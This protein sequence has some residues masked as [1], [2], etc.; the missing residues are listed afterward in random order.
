MQVGFSQGFKGGLFGGMTFSQVDGDQWAGYNKVGLQVGAYSRFLLNDEW[1][2]VAELKYIQKGSIHSDKENPYSYFR[3]KL[4][5]MEIPLLLNYQLNEH[6]AFG[7]GFAYGQLMNG[8]VDDASG[9]VSEE[10]L[11]YKNMDI[12][13]IAQFKYLFNEHLWADIKFAYSVVYITNESPRQF[14]NLISFSIGYEI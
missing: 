7:G 11:V 2:F 4:N 13:A 6:F 8:K 1:S 3:I 14:N 9:T 12:N 10:Q 5:Y